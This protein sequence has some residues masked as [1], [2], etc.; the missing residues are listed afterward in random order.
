MVERWTLPAALLPIAV[1]AVAVTRSSL[2]QYGGGPD[3]RGGA[4]FARRPD[5]RRLQATRS[6]SARARG[7]RSGA[8]ACRGPHGGRQAMSDQ[9]EQNQGDGHGV[10]EASTPQ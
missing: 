3:P 7:G 10:I 5:D 8:D 6:L 4:R 9:S 2:G 1:G